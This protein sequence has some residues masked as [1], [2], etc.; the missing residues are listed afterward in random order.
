[1]LKRMINLYDDDVR[2]ITYV[3]NYESFYAL[4]DSA[5]K[6]ILGTENQWFRN[7]TKEEVTGYLTIAL[8]V[9]AI[10]NLR[11]YRQRLGVITDRISQLD[12]A[13]QAFP[14]PRYFR[15]VFREFSRPMEDDLDV[16]IPE[17]D[18]NSDVPFTQYHADLPTF[19]RISAVYRALNHVSNRTLV[20]LDI[21]QTK[22]VPISFYYK[23]ENVLLSK[24]FLPEWRTR[25]IMALKHC[26]FT[27]IQ[28]PIPQTNVIAELIQDSV[29]DL[30]H[31]VIRNR[32]V[33]GR[34]FFRIEVLRYN[35]PPALVDSTRFP[36][37]DED[38]HSQTPPRRT[39][40][41]STRK[42]PVGKDQTDVK[43]E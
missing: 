17:I 2:I 3:P 16:Y 40:K 21:E 29:S 6:L 27:S 1:M 13:S 11:A 24:T 7:V 35:P 38:L 15:D 43:D 12:D 34:R 23:Q 19:D 18:F 14:V 22:P 26:R 41:P 42:R 39:G 31:G 36:T 28:S 5:H 9:Y 33:N 4:C 32:N 8:K 37:N 25:A 20:P 30:L 10:R